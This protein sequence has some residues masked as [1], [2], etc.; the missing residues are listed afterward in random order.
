M[1]KEGRKIGRKE[2][3][4]MG[5]KKGRWDKGRR[6]DGTEEGRAKEKEGGREGGIVDRRTNF[7]FPLMAGK[8]EEEVRV[9]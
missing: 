7:A 4:E 2:R 9:L 5:R 1:G 8:N 6:K 3:K